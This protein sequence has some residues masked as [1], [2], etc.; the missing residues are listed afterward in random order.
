MLLSMGTPRVQQRCP[1]VAPRRL[2][3]PPPAIRHA[4]ALRLGWPSRTRVA[5]CSGG[6]RAESD[7]QQLQ[8][9]LHAHHV[10]LAGSQEACIFVEPGGSRI[11]QNSVNQPAYTTAGRLHH[12]GGGT[13]L[14]GGGLGGRARGAAARAGQQ[15]R[16]GGWG[17][18]GTGVLPLQACRASAALAVGESCA[19]SHWSCL[20]HWSCAQCSRHSPARLHAH[21]FAHLPRQHNTGG[22]A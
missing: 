9:S 4:L 20:C 8:V 3:G 21:T 22:T 15:V 13:V 14:E 18:R 16:R 19:Q 2:A 7:E 5:C 12:N 6:G 1:L 10:I 11:P 17:E